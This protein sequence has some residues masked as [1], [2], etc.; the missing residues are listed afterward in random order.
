MRAKRKVLFVQLPQLD[1]DLRSAHENVPLAAT[2]LQHAAAAAGEDRYHEFAILPPELQ[3]RPNRV[4]IPELLRTPPAVVACT[5]YLWNIERT[6]RFVR[7]LKEVAPATSIFLG[8]P[9]VARSH[10]F[11]FRESQADAIAVGEGEPVFPAL[12]AATRKGGTVDFD[13]VALRK[14]RRYIWGRTPPGTVDLPRMSPEPGTY[15]YAPD[16]NGMAYLET[17]R[18]CPMRCTYCRYPHLRKRMSFLPID[19]ILARIQALARQGAREIRFIDPT[20]NAHPHFRELLAQLASLRSRGRLDFFAE[21]NAERITPED[22]RALRRA[23]FTEIEA[24]VQSLDPSVLAAVRRPSRLTELERGIRAMRREGIKVTVDLMYALPLQ[25]RS[26]ITRAL[27]WAMTLDRSNVQCMQTLLLPG[28]ELRARRRT[29]KLASEPRPPYAVTETS[30]LSTR[31]IRDLEHRLARHPQLRS[32]IPTPLFAGA[33]LPLFRERHTVAPGDTPAPGGT[34]RR[35]YLFKGQELFPRRAELVRFVQRAIRADPDALLQFVLVP[36]ME[37]P[38][39]LLE[40]LVSEIRH[41]PR[42]LIDRYGAVALDSKIAS[43]RLFVLARPAARLSRSW[44]G[45]A[46]HLLADAFF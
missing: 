4:L 15:G 39:D 19:M 25:R 20:F 13:T 11:L 42:H 7:Q 31:E 32:D 5:L 3:V 28:T 21:L 43:R 46:E 45:E 2:L 10:P 1:N 41:H 6:L 34:L 36:A 26:H 35:A 30:T 29:W 8:G 22:A 37:E 33:R 16:R 23:G 38:L 14:G 18:G 9:E 12:L 17:S 27:R 40:A 44:L 24:G